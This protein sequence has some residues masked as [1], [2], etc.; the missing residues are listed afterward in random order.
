MDKKF[1]IWNSQ[2]NEIH[3]L[4]LHRW[5]HTSEI[6]WCV[7]GE[8]IGFEQDGKGERFLRPV[9]VLW[10]FGRY[11]VWII[12]LTTSLK[13]NLYHIDIGIVM[14][15]QAFAIS[16]QIRLVDTKRMLEKVSKVNVSVFLKLKKSIIALLE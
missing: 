3:K 7:M 12:P 6:W 16:T 9:V 15:K 11:T 2:K 10:S 13:E 4:E 5:C 1:D 8:N 14:N